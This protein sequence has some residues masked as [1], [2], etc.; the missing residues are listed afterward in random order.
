[1]GGHQAARLVKHEQP[2]ALAR[3]QRLAVDGDDVVAGDIER[4]RIDDAAVDGDAALHDPFLGVAAR[5]KTGA[6]QHL[7]NALAGFLFTRRT[8][9]AFLEIRLALAVLAAAAERRPFGKHLAV[10]LVVAA[11][12]FGTRVAARMFLPGAAAFTRV[13]LAIPARPVEF[14]TVL[15]G[16]ILART[17]ETGTVALWSVSARTFVA[18]FPGTV[19]FRPFAKR[20]VTLWTIAA[21]LVKI[22]RAV[23]G[24][25]GIAS[26]M[27]GRHGVARL[28]PHLTDA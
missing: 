2:R 12:P 16:A 8:G 9:S 22:A 20:A 23:T 26:G 1:M 21:R 4:R 17:V 5:G 18:S 19:E 13:A 24:R 7:G 27:S 14:R 15:A 6:R 10:V 11:R 25:T 3:R 28:P